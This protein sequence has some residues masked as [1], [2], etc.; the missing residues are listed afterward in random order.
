MT[1]FERWSFLLSAIG[2]AVTGLVYLWMKYFLTPVDPWA[3]I[4]HPWQPWVLK[5]HILVAPLLV[6][7]VGLIAVKHIWRHLRQGRKDGRRSGLLSFLV[8]APMVV[9]GYVIQSVSSEGA[10]RVVAW[11]HIGAS[12]LFVAGVAVHQLVVRRPGTQEP[13]WRRWRSRSSAGNRRSQSDE[14]MAP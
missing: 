5:A 1:R 7:S 12:L 11:V 14:V 2:T 9:S 3:V 13:R 6:F 4:N 10:L 8:L